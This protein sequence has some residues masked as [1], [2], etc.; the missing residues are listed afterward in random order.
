M[1]KINE[2][3]NELYT[4]VDKEFSQ[5]KPMSLIP[6]HIRDTDDDYYDYIYTL[7]SLYEVTK[8]GSHINYYITSIKE[9]EN[10]GI[11]FE[12]SSFDDLND[13]TTFYPMD[14]TVLDK[15]I[16]LETVKNLQK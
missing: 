1:K 14:F 5:L 8:Y 16:L 10:G 13:A 7:P 11:C 6:E 12:A 4:E 2:L 3:L 9:S 15:I